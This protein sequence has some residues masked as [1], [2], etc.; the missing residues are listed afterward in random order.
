MP[1]TTDD[2]VSALA[3]DNNRLLAA[4]KALSSMYGST[5]DRADGCLVM[6]DTGIERFEKAH[7]L[8]QD[9]IKKSEGRQLAK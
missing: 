1:A 2:D 5:W 4:L 7:K 9:A 3:A 6:M 8:A